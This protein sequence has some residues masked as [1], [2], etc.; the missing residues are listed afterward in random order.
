MANKKITGIPEVDAMIAQVNKKFEKSV[1]SEE[2][3]SAPPGIPTGSDALDAALGIGGI[4]SRRVTEILGEPSSG[5]TSL[6]LQ[7]LANDQASRPSDSDLID[8]II[9]LEQTITEEF[10][11]GFGI[12]TEKVLHVR[13]TSAEEALQIAIDLPK[14]GKIGFVLLDSVG[15]MQAAA[16]IQKEA[17]ESL[18]GGVSKMMHWAMRQIS[19]ISEE[20]NTTYVFINHI[21]YKP[22][23]TYG[24]P[25]TSPGGNALPYFSSVRLEVLKSKP[26]TDNP[27]AFIMHVK[28]KKNKCGKPHSIKDGVEFTFYYGRGTDPVAEAL[29]MARTLGFIRHSAGQSKIRL[30][31][32]KEEWIAP[33]LDMPKGKEAC[34]TWYRTHPDELQ[35]LKD[36]VLQHS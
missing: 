5:K 11:Q 18:V 19:K 29:E 9:D 32:E 12:N 23:V 34:F 8:L 26:C 35:V 22:G 25:R 20:T 36:L 24:D 15:A 17:G 31:L 7:I 3:F 30:D 16:E 10:M 1:F 28:V 33:S 21:T 6:A 27:G 4:P 2:A 13:P 14:T